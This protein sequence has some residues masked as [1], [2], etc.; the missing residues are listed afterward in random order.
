MHEIEGDIS[1]MDLCLHFLNRS[2][3]FFP[4]INVLLKPRE[5]SL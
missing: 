1:T 2:I 5:K 3:T 4:I